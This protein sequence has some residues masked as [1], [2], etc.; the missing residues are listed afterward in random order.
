GAVLRFDFA[1]DLPLVE[2]DETQIRQIVM[3]LI[4]NAS[5]AIG[6]RSGFITLRTG[7]M[8]A[9]RDY[10]R[11]TDIDDELPEGMY[12]YVAVAATGV[13]MSADTMSRMFDPFFSTKFTGRGLGLSATLGIVRGHRGTVKVASALG[14]GTT[15]PV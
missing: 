13:G 3:N 5:D 12:A 4:T 14:S 11:S 6:Q 1:P 15:F 2:A 9:D 7:V 8:I 10:L